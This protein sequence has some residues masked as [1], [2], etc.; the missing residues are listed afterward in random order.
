M[1]FF[2]SIEWRTV[3]ENNERGQAIS[4]TQLRYRLIAGEIVSPTQYLIVDAIVSEVTLEDIAR[5]T[6]AMLDGQTLG[7]VLV[8]LSEE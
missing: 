2:S 8:R 7:R 5:V 1:A 4:W 6:R 3:C